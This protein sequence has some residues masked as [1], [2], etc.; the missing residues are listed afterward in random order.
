MANVVAFECKEV[1]EVFG[2]EGRNVMNVGAFE[3]FELPW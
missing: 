1:V 2:V 3:S